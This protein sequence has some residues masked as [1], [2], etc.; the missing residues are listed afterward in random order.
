MRD[1]VTALGGLGQPTDEEEDK[2]P[3][4]GEEGAFS[5]TSGTLASLRGV[6][7]Y[8]T[9]RVQGS[10]MNQRVSILIDSGKN[11][12]FFDAHLVQKRGIP[13]DTF[14]GFSVLVLG[15][16]TMQCMQYVHHSMSLWDP[17][18]WWITSL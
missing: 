15:D 12:N 16:R 5:P 18:P 3:S 1:Q 14:E 10:V 4:R 9:L 13:T 17:T 11:H 2:S 7:K 6:P 8:L